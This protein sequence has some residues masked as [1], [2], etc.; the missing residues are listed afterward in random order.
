MLEFIFL[1]VLSPLLL[2]SI[3]YFDALR[4]RKRGVQ[5][6]PASVGLTLAA[7][8]VVLGSIFNVF[9]LF[10]YSHQALRIALE[11]VPH[12]IVLI[13]YGIIR[14]TNYEKKARQ[15]NPPLP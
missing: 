10:F 14:F 9:I 7:V 4:Y 2:F 8:T 11:Y 5:V 6:N 12:A 15:V 13:A 1:L 3:G